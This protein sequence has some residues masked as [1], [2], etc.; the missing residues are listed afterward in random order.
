MAST[1]MSICKSYGLHFLNGRLSG[2]SHGSTSCI[3]NKGFSVIDYLI[4]DSAFFEY[5]KDFSVM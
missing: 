4:A 5:V 1:L 3:A 2:Y